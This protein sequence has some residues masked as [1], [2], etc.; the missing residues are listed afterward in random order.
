MAN[1]YR[2]FAFALKIEGQAQKDWLQT[3]IDRRKEEE[4]PQ[5][6]SN[7]ADFDSHF[8]SDNDYIMFSD[9]T[10]NGNVEHIAEIVQAFLKHFKLRKYFLM[11]W[12]DVCDK[13]RIDG[14]HGGSA[15][16][17]SKKTIWFDEERWIRANTKGLTLGNEGV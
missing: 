14:F 5:S 13:Q 12:A 11:S 6:G 9:D 10:E 3:E 1:Y 16:V 2:H 8:S 15:I 7:M 4:D 17:T